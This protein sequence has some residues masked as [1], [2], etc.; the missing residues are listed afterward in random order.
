MQKFLK[1]ST[2]KK[3]FS[4]LAMLSLVMPGVLLQMPYQQ[5]AKAVGV[6]AGTVIGNQATASYKDGNNNSYN[7]SSNLVNTTVSAVYGIVLTP[8]GTTA[9]PG[10]QQNA[11]PGNIVYYPYTLTNAGNTSD[12]YTLTS[13]VQTGAGTLFT[14]ANKIVYYDVN[15][16]GIVDTGDTQIADGGST[17]SIPADGD[18]KLIVAYQVP[19]TA[20]GGN[21]AYVDLRGISVGDGTKTDIDNVNKTTVVNDAVVAVTKSVNLSSTDPSTVATNRELTYTLNASNTG[22]QNANAIVLVDAIPANTTFKVGSATGPVGT[23]IEYSNSLSGSTFTYTPAGIYDTNV[24]RVRYT[25]TSLAP[26]NNR[27]FVFLVRVDNTAPAGVIPNAAD[28]NYKLFD[29]TTIV[30]DDPSDGTND[31]YN[32]TPSNGTSPQGFTNIT[33]TT[34]NTKSAAQISHA[35][36][37]VI[38]PGAVAGTENPP[39]AAAT[40]DRTTVASASAGTYVYFRNRVTNNGNSTDL[41]DI[42]LDTGLSQLPLGAVVKFYIDGTV[43][44]N[45]TGSQ[46]SLSP[47]LN[48]GGSAA[49]DTANM[50]VAGTYNIITEVFIP[51]NSVQS[52]NTTAAAIIGDSTVTVGNGAI[53]AA[54]D[55][56]TIGGVNYM[57]ASVAGNVLTL[58]TTLTAAV[59]SGDAVSRNVISVIRATSSNG[60]TPID[61]TTFG[62]NTYDTTADIVSSIL[63]PSV[64]L[65]NIFNNSLVNEANQTETQSAVGATVSYPLNIRNT[66]GVADTYNLTA[67]NLPAGATATFYPLIP[68]STTT[69][70]DTAIAAGDTSIDLATAAGYT[71]GDT[72]IIAGQTFTVGS[73]S[74]TTINF[75]AGQSLSANSLPVNG[76]DVVE[77]GNTP[78]SNTSLIAGGGAEQ[79]VAV[80]SSIPS[81]PATYNTLTFTT[82]STNNSAISNS[83]TDTLVVPSFR[84]FTLVQDRSG[85]VP[86]GGTLTY[87]H[88]IT[89]TGN[90]AEMFTVT[91]P[92]TQNGLTYQLIDSTGTIVSTTSGANYQLTTTSLAAAGTYNFTVKVI[93]PSNT[94]TNTV[95]SIPVIA[96]ETTS[97]QTATNTDVTTVVEGFIQLSKAASS[98]TYGTNGLDGT[99]IFAANPPTTFSPAT[100]KPGEVLEYTI[101]YTNIGSETANDVRI[102]DLIP[103]N[104]TYI[105]GSLKIGATTKTDAVD[106]EVG[107]SADG[108]A[109]GTHFFVGT[110]ATSVLGGTVPQG[111]SSTVTF[112]VRVN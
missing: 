73:V 93:V 3:F 39:Y 5:E 101:T 89:N 57:V 22:N 78:I 56:I 96:T 64:D 74:G 94:P 28:Y 23:T 13:P 10:Q 72:I 25:L 32:T 16:N 108:S 44:T 54:N 112:R 87:A 83:I 68:A 95:S 107:G 49:P 41:F 14:P 105:P 36:G 52:S 6:A 59:S 27:D 85:T 50:A 77:R 8:N 81:T 43:S 18:I 51:A 76:G 9:A 62:L 53:F 84:N 100:V 26:N 40:S 109:S 37:A 86:P 55:R 20:T 98:Y 38:S 80:I 82:T 35:G 90:V 71:P 29:N 31:Y 111:A 110:G 7:S 91:V 63:A 46:A 4:T 60:G 106:T 47:L 79:V 67:T 48:T 12:T 45:P 70:V 92:Q 17:V 30:N 1:K 66:G 102:T 58:S 21:V 19:V 88:T 34:V 69:I 65:S 97:S 75:I 42:S 15:R 103:A 2:S 99:L 24:K 61:A 104:T 11:T 33:S